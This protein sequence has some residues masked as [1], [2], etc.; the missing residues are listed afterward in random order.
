MGADQR[1]SVFD[2]AQANNLKILQMS[3][4]SRNLES[5]FRDVTKG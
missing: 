3:L 2:F 1:P 5:V 4:K